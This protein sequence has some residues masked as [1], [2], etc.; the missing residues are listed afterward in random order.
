MISTTT[1][2]VVKIFN[3]ETPFEYLKAL[4]GRSPHLFHWHTYIRTIFIRQ[5]N[6]L[7]YS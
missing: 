5:R 6:G 4:F 2:D 1:Y 3:V 7:K